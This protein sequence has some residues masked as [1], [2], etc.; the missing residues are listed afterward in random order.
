LC[1]IRF[2]W[3]KEHYDGQNCSQHG[4]E[5]G[6]QNASWIALCANL[7]LLTFG[8]NQAAPNP[9]LSLNAGRVPRASSK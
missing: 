3:A 2:I 9:T 6:S 4:D 1:E 8:Q 7:R 5:E